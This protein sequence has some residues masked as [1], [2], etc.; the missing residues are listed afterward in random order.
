MSSPG[1]RTPGDE[2]LNA[3]VDGALSSAE[4]AE[5]ARL[6]VTSAEIAHR[7]AVLHDLKAGVAAM[8]EDSTVVA[9]P[10]PRKATREGHLPRWGLAAAA[11]A[12][13][14]MLVL[15]LSWSTDVTGEAVATAQNEPLADYVGM[16]DAWVEAGNAA[17]LGRPAT[18]WVEN[19]MQ[20]TGLGLVHTSRHPTSDGGL[21]QHLAFI[22]PKGC[23]LSLFEVSMA[24]DRAGGLDLSITDG[25]LTARW[26]AQGYGYA[27]VARN[28]DRA[29]FV[30]IAAAVQDASRERNGVDAQILADLRDARQPCIG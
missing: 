5:I 8:V 21:A 15:S 27:L 2:A 20:A 23:R 12:A 18:E 17:P 3:Y 6:A 4:A 24:G 9:P 26:T 22:G 29:R 16:H 19:L 28:M 7:I 13:A 30:T 11:M 10:L 14:I 25:L 1:D